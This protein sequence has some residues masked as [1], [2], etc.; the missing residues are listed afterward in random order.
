MTPDVLLHHSDLWH[1]AARATDDGEAAS[2]ATSAAVGTAAAA[3]RPNTVSTISSRT[4][5]AKVRGAPSPGALRL[6]MRP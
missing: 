4:P 5:A 1:S 6:A 2:G 3:P